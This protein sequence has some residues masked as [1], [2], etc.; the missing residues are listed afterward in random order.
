MLN[1]FSSLY[2]AAVVGIVIR[3]GL[4]IDPHHENKPNKQK[5]ALHKPSIHFKSSLKWLYISS[6][7]EASFIKVVVVYRVLRNLR[8][9]RF[10]YIY[11]AL[12]LFAI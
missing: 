8:R 7:I 6:K 2:V 11:V 3:H 10:G 1:K 9:A 12:G 4:N 5:L